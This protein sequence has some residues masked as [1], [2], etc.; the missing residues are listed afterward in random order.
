MSGAG[1]SSQPAAGKPSALQKRKAEVARSPA[2]TAGGGKRPR[3]NRDAAQR[4]I[5]A[6]FAA[7]P[8]SN[9]PQPPSR[10]ATADQAEHGSADDPQEAAE[11]VGR[12]DM[13]SPTTTKDQPMPKPAF[14][15]NSGLPPRGGHSRA[16]KDMIPTGN[17]S[18]P[19]ADAATSAP[20]SLT[21]PSDAH[22]GVAACDTQDPDAEPPVRAPVNVP[23]IAPIT[24]PVCAPITTPVSAP[25]GVTRL[26]PLPIVE[27]PRPARPEAPPDAVLYPLAEYEPVAHAC[28]QAGEPMPYLHLARAFQV[29]SLSTRGVRTYVY[30]G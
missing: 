6:F 22:E 15:L 12:S 18:T 5:T 24:T 9:P 27:L 23:V 29:P 10:E 8:G 14:L 28:W 21:G 7:S 30:W 25:V 2:G 19:A 17:A 16:P 26:G 13:C 4:S 11:A 1:A 20:S 3:Q